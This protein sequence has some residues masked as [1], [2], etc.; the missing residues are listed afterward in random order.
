MEIAMGVPIPSPFALPP[1]GG[2][3]RGKHARETPD[4]EGLEVRAA[5]CLASFCNSLARF[6]GPDAFR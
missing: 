4:A 1:Q 3:C 6:H 2:G 5:I